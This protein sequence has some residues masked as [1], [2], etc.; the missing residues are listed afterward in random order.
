MANCYDYLVIATGSKT[1]YFGN[2]IE[3]NSMAWKPYRSRSIL[4]SD[5]WKF[6]TS[7][8]NYRCS[9]TKQSH[10]FCLVGGGPT[11]ELA[12]AL[13]EM[14]SHSAKDYPDLDIATMQINLIQSGDRTIPWARN[15]LK[16]PEFLTSLGVKNLKNVRVTNYDWRTIT[17]NSDLTFETTVIWTAGVK[18]LLLQDW[19]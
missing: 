13:A 3:R 15:P 12:G 11:G 6:W 4:E 7:R 17:T 9:R 8:F 19:W 1:N 16:P 5:S 2:E 10:Q 14:K 18:G